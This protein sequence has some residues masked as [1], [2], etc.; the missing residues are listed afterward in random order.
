MNG[1]AFENVNYREIQLTPGGKK[2][3]KKPTPISVLK[4]NMCLCR[5]TQSERN[6]V[7][8]TKMRT[9]TAAAQS[10]IDLS[11]AASLCLIKQ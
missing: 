7:N 10:N 9:Q 6:P 1:L 3:K 5:Y 4:E 11:V 8:P 2:K